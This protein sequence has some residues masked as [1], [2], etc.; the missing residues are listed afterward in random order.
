MDRIQNGNQFNHDL[1][2][3]HMMDQLG[4]E[5]TDLNANLTAKVRRIDDMFARAMADGFV[6]A[7]EEKEL[8]QASYNLSLEI[9]QM[10]KFNKGSDNSAAAL[11]IA[12]GLV[13]LIGAAI[14]IKQLRS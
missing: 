10:A 9:E 6:D 14:G 1:P 11:T 4:L 2:H 13:L 8:I 5:L 12:G 7:Q 3:E